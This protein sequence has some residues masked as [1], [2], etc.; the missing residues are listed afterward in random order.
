MVN[1]KRWQ[2]EIAT[3]K[4]AIANETSW[5]FPM[6]TIN[7]SRILITF[8]VLFTILL[9][10]IT[11]FA[12]N[13]YFSIGFGTKS[14]GLAGAAV[15]LPQDSMVAAVNPAGM[16]HIGNQWD[17]GLAFFNPNRSYT[18]NA[19]PGFAPIPPGTFESSNDLFLIPHFGVNWMLDDASSVG[20]SIGGNGGMNTEYQTATFVNFAPPGSPTEFQATSPTGVDLVQLFVGFTYSRKVWERHSFGVTP[21]FAV[22]RFKA[23]GLQPFKGVSTS[24]ND[25]TN[26]GNDYSYGGGV[27]IGW[28]GEFTDWLTVG[29]SVQSKLYMS[30]FDKYKGLF[31]EGGDFD[32]PPVYNVGFSTKLNP[33]WTF[34]FEVQGILF[35]E[36]K[37]ISNSNDFPV[38]PGSLGGDDGLGF[39][40]E[41][42]TIFKL[43][44]QWDARPDWTLRLGYSTANQVIPSSQALF[45]I[46]APATV[47]DHI[48]FGVTKS[49]GERDEINFAYT[50]AFN[51]KVSGTSPNTGTQTGFLE[52]DQNEFEI[53]WSR[54]F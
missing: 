42:M 17:L 13:G 16:V 18:A 49:F 25:V 51:E 26:N 6:E 3:G 41:D 12:T 44:V 19:T 20:L 11:G 52:M 50:H 35:E 2:C 37:A 47:T 7:T 30:K 27:R 36:V 46:L 39:G 4:N 15:A 34:A 38:T 8:L 22:Q 14:K 23:E 32:I 24:P 53:S 45:N 40:W 1:Y 33:E 43:G 29:A 5:R 21:I 54:K 10:P 31:A 28:L 48:A 9:M